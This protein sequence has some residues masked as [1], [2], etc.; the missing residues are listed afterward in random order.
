MASF[1]CNYQHAFRRNLV[2]LSHGGVIGKS[3]FRVADQPEK[4][5]DSNNMMSHFSKL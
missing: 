3:T 2:D 5:V 1:G 4:D